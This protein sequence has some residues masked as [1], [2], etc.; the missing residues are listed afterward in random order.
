MSLGVGHTVLFSAYIWK[1]WTGRIMRN[2]RQHL[3]FLGEAAASIKMLTY[4]WLGYSVIHIT[5]FSKE[6]WFA[7]FALTDSEKKVESLK[8][9]FICLWQLYVFHVA[10]QWRWHG[11]TAILG[12]INGSHLNREACGKFFYLVKETFCNLLKV[13]LL[14]TVIVIVFTNTA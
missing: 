2:M 3:K 11:M 12:L 4:Q 7:Q 6:N 5:K 14:I 8:V 10:L 13:K 1:S 9:H